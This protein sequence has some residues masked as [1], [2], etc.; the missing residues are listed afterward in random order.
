MIALVELKGTSME[1]THYGIAHFFMELYAVKGEILVFLFGIGD[2]GIEV[3][4]MLCRKELFKG[5]VEFCTYA[6]AVKPFIYINCDFDRPIIGG[7]VFENAC[8][9]IAC[10]FAVFYCGYVGII[11]GYA[12]DTLCELFNGGD[13]IL[14]CY[15]G[16]FNVGTVYF[17]KLVSVLLGNCSYY[18]GVLLIVP[19]IL[20]PQ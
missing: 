11:C 10:Y 13:V 15:G 6:F 7:S 16:V 8:I 5:G 3:C 14:E 9:G 12:A 20:C 1:R 17:K 4:Y 19:L 18:H 2:A